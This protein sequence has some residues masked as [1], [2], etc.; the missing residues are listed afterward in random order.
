MRHPVLAVLAL[1]LSA[2]LAHAETPEEKGLRIVT[3]AYEAGKGYGSADD[4]RAR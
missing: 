3:A 2:S 1:G 4:E